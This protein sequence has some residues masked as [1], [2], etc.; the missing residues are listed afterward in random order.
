MRKLCP[1]AYS[2]IITVFV[3]QALDV[4]AMGVTLYCFV[5]GN[6]SLSTAKKKAHRIK[7][8]QHFNDFIL[9]VLSQCP[10]YDEYI[11]SL[12]NKIKNKPV[13]FPET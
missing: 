11:V 1:T 2:L 10:F 3:Y 9:S 4:W 6:V 8:Q 13:E 7:S 5:F 12:H